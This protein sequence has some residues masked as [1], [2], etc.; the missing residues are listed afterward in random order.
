MCCLLVGW[1]DGGPVGVGV[2]FSLSLRI[3]FSQSIFQADLG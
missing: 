3:G 1:L 2:G